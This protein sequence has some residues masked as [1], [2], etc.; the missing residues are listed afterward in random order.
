MK[1]FKEI[2][3]VRYS[4]QR[5]IRQDFLQLFV[6]ALACSGKIGY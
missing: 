5:F 2:S 1:Y 3:C 6:V 4:L